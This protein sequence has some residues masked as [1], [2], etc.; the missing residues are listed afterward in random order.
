V[1]RAAEQYGF[2]VESIRAEVHEHVRKQPVTGLV[3]ALRLTHRANQTPGQRQPGGLA[4]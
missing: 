4:A 2:Q 1:V 3:V